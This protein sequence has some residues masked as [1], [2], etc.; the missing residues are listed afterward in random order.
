LWNLILLGA[1]TFSKIEVIAIFIK[2]LYSLGIRFAN[3]RIELPPKKNLKLSVVQL[4]ACA[5]ASAD[6]RRLSEF[7]RG[8]FFGKMR[9]D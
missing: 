5:E 3:F 1:L 6:R 8:D 2:I 4:P 7:S 9:S